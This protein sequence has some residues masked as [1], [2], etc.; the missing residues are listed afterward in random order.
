MY[1]IFSE[2]LPPAEEWQVTKDPLRGGEEERG[3]R[4]AG[5][6][7]LTHGSRGAMVRGLII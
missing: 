3:K 5:G 6:D 7:L 4:R 1:G 2:T